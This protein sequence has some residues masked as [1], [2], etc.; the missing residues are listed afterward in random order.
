MAE[1]A[2]RDDSIL[3]TQLDRVV[4]GVDFSPPSLAAVNW[5][6]HHFAPEADC[7]VV[8]AVDLPPAP[9]F[10]RTDLPP[11]EEMLERA[12]ETTLGKLQ[13][14]QSRDSWGTLD[15]VVS[16]GRPEDIVA[17]EAR[18]R[19]AGIVVVG[20]HA[21]PRGLWATLGNTAEA[22]VHC[23]PVPVLVA[24]NVPEHRP[25]RIL[26]AV[27]DSAHARLALRWAHMLA[28]RFDASV[29]AF[30]AFQTTYLAIAEAVSGMQ[31]GRGLEQEQVDQTRAWLAGMVRD[32]GFA[33]G[34]ASLRVEEGDP[35]AALVAAQRGGDFDLLVTG[36]R[37]AGGASRMLVGSV[38]NA[39]LRGASRPVLVVRE[40]GD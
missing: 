30:H 15:L 13:E 26:V 36:S 38:A 14:L 21:R 8:H 11:R 28:R 34:E 9:R 39:V 4:I 27:D 22:L 20:E 23:S 33:E 24:R 7:T 12:R 40:R 35:A 6:R 2:D 10:V 5:I 19:G 18:D 37:G 1:T 32:A 3:E 17:R 29:T 16:P 31:A 25:R